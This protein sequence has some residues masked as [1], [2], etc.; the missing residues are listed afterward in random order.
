MHR[1]PPVSDSETGIRDKDLRELIM[2]APVAIAAYIGPEF[3]V[4]LVNDKCL[5]IFGKTREEVLHRP[6]FDVLPEGREQG[7]EEIHRSVYE[8]GKIFRAN[9]IEARIKHRDG[10]YA[11]WYNL[12]YQ[13]LRDEHGV[14]I[15]VIGIA[16]DVSEAVIAR[17]RIE[18]HEDV[19]QNL[20][21]QAPVPI[22]I[23]T[24]KDMIVEQMNERYSE[25]LGI[26]FEKVRNRP[27]LEAFPSLKE[28]GF[29]E[30]LKKVFET[31]EAYH[32][33]EYAVDMSPYGRYRTE[34]FNIV[35]EPL[36]DKNGNVQRIMIV[37][38]DVT[39]SIE[40][41]KNIEQAE[42]R[43]RIATQAADT[44]TWDWY[45]Q[46]GKIICDDRCK[47]L[48]GL[49]RNVD[50]DYDKFFAAIHPDDR[51]KTSAAIMSAMNPAS[52][53]DYEIEFRS[54]GL[55]DGKTRWLKSKGKVYFNSNGEAGRF[56]GII[57]D[58][59]D[60]KELEERK[61]HFIQMASHELKTPVTSIKGYVQLLLNMLKEDEN[62]E[63]PPLLVKSSLIS[64]DKQ[65]VRLTR[66]MSELL[67]LTRI[68][69]GKMELNKEVFNLNELVIDT[70]QDILYTNNQHTIHIFHEV[71]CV[72]EA[73]RDRI[74]Q[75]IINLLTNAIKY[76]PGSRRID[77]T[78]RKAEESQVAVAVKDNGIG[79]NY[80]DLEKV[81]ERFFR[82]SGKSE[83]TFPGFGIGL[84]I[85]RDIVQRHGGQIL[86]KSE[87]G[88]GSEFIFVLPC[89]EMLKQ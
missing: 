29:D 2:K 17:R 27:V 4:E 86:V 61:N 50:L 11:A 79:I 71:G 52:G 62:A 60:A 46:T 84:F 65:V 55:E 15:G 24:G 38:Y 83:Q 76:S 47:E 40:T 45:P 57:L 88:K 13:P 68:E 23:L 54:I 43:M 26:P 51:E 9:E 59:H 16:T 21:T 35:Y 75:V 82:A 72:V 42:E 28:K 7:F 37:A 56:T 49:P 39:A 63:L 78:I 73:D 10:E 53:G 22:I 81:F 89:K 64:I 44:G 74:G 41:R 77:V 6:I 5:E 69:S 70:V 66:L 3:I 1:Q 12:V 33:T 30:L 19:L 8:T 25:I 32:G 34:Y 48:F 20:I 67:D 87:L 85:S 18:D 14:I 80:T 31:G 36:K 58:I